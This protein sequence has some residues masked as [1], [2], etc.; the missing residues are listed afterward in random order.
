MVDIDMKAQN[1]FSDNLGI[2][3]LNIIYTL[4][5]AFSQNIVWGWNMLG[6][7]YNPDNKYYLNLFPNAVQNTLYGFNSTYFQEDTLEIGEGYWL[8]FDNAETI[9]LEGYPINSLTLNLAEGWNMICGIS[10]NMPLSNINDPNNIIIPGTLFGF[11]GVYVANDTIVQGEGYWVRANSAG[12]ISMDIGSAAVSKTAYTLE[13]L[14]MSP[15]INIEDSRNNKQR[16]YFNVELSDPSHK[17]SYSLPPLPP[18]GSFDVRFAGDYRVT[19]SD[20]AIINIQTSAYPIKINFEK[21]V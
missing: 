12:Q 11:D 2:Y 8:R 7:A 18:K 9:P 3:D 5:E 15:V 1:S 6:L 20:K 21:N 13:D 16:L 14:S 17:L 19:E 4:S 10:A